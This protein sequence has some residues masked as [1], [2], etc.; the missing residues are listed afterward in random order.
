MIKNIKKV[1]YK[2]IN[3]KN[4]KKVEYKDIN[5]KKYLKN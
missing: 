2:D 5:D 3:D 4:I 1:E